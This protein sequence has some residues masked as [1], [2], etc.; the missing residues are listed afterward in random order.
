MLFGKKFD[1]KQKNK[2]IFSAIETNDTVIYSN[3]QDIKLDKLE[4][5]AD[6]NDPI[7][8]QV[9]LRGSGKTN[10]L[11]NIAKKRDVIYIDFTCNENGSLAK[12]ASVRILC[13]IINDY[14]KKIK[15][16]KILRYKTQEILDIFLLS[17]LIYHGIFREI[18]SDKTPEYFFRFSINSGQ[19]IIADIFNDLL[20]YNLSSIDNIA[21]TFKNN[22]LFEYDEVG[23]LTNLFENKFLPRDIGQNLL[24]DDLKG[25]F[26]VFADSI[27]NFRSY[28]Y[29]QSKN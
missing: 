2:K 15:D 3:L 11:Y 26:H 28:R 13:N 22:V 17:N 9:Q 1:P 25:F 10:L 29:Y 5:R 27:I 16:L 20:K 12:S 21:R 14:I 18:I 8:I 19:D 4:E 7:L 6:Q 23:C 24:K